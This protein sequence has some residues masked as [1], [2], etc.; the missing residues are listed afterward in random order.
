MPPPARNVPTVS[1]TAGLKNPVAAPVSPESSATTQIAG[2]PAIRSAASRPCVAARATSA[3]TITARRETRSATTPPIRTDAT[4]GSVRAA[5]TMPTSD[6][7]PPSPSTANASAMLTIRSP[8]TDTA[9]APNTS[10]K[11]RC[12]RTARLSGSRRTRRAGYCAKTVASGQ[13]G[14]VRNRLRYPGRPRRL[15]TAAGRTPRNTGA[16]SERAWRVDAVRELAPDPHKDVIMRT[17]T[18]ALALA[19]TLLAVPAAAAEQKAEDPPA[20]AETALRAPLGGHLTVR[21]QM[22]AE[23]YANLQHDLIARAGTLAQRLDRSGAAERTRLR[24]QTPDAIRGR[25]RTLERRL[26]TPTASPVL[27]A[28]AACESG[29][30]PAADTGNGFYGKYQFTLET[31]QAVGGTGNPARASEAEQDRRAATLYA[32]AG[33]SPWPVCGR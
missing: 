13:E 27:E 29:G 18:T 23:R 1:S 7:D 20:P 26:N 25:I 5:R 17:R 22:R 15:G 4:S 24:G 12:R 28:I 2:A 3:V 11:S 32:R 30:N 10:R 16:T 6:G 19:S 21:G 8:S 14:C 33:A 9:N 31:W